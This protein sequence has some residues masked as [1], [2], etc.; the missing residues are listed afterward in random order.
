MSFV[1]DEP[2]I[3][4]N[5]EADDKV[6][7]IVDSAEK[8]DSIKELPTEN[9]SESQNNAPPTDSVDP[10]QDSEQSHAPETETTEEPQPEKIAEVKQIPPEEETQENQISVSDSVEKSLSANSSTVTTERK[11]ENPNP[12]ESQPEIEQKSSM[13]QINEQNES[14][15]ALAPAKKYSSV[16]MEAEEH[17]LVL[18]ERHERDITAKIG[19]QGNLDEKFIVTNYVNNDTNPKEPHLTCSNLEVVTK[20]CF[21]G[22]NDKLPIHGTEDWGQPKSI[23]VKITFF[24]TLSLILISRFSHKNILLSEL[25]RVSFWSSIIFLQES[26]S[27]AQL[28]KESTELSLLL[29]SLSKKKMSWLFMKAAKSFSGLWLKMKE[30]RL[31]ILL[32]KDL[33]SMSNSIKI[34]VN[35]LCSPLQVDLFTYTELRIFSSSGESKR[36]F[37]PFLKKLLS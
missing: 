36:N 34:P 24:P 22:D 1:G 30:S 6:K 19:D 28:K 27:S 9:N 3:Q 31:S 32:K 25:Q 33:A 13:D 4:P 5:G 2:N 23:S 18:I 14:I 20:N 8:T 21:P 37:S 16:Y 11:D 10:S 15:P 12:L 7:E 29:I 17:P 35:I 26:K